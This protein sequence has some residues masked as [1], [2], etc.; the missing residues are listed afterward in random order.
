[1]QEIVEIKDKN[2]PSTQFNHLSTLGEGINC[3][4]W[5]T[6]TPTPAPFVAEARSSSEFYSNK[7]LV[8]FKKS[9]E[10]QTNWVSHWNNFMKELQNYVKKHHTTGL[11]WNPRG[12]DAGASKPVAAPPKAGGPPPPPPPSALA[13]APTTPAKGA[14]VDT[15]ALFASINKGEGITSGLKKVTA[16]MKT[17]NRKDNT[18]LVP[19]ETSKKSEAAPKAAGAAKKGTP[20]IELQGNKWIVEFQDN[21]KSIE[22]K[23]T[24]PKQAIYIYKSDNCVVKI[25]GKINSVCIDGCKKTA[26]VFENAISGCEL[27]NCNSVEVQILGAIPS[28]AID[29]CS[30]VQ[31]FL[32]KEALNANIV[33]SKS[34]AMNILI[35]G[36]TKDADLIELP[37]PEQFQTAIKNNKLITTSMV[38]E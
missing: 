18:S 34:D 17:K 32:S 37:I 35:P 13:A 11:S 26:V 14:A 29:K 6:I 2:R 5:I 3:L 33:S 30:G 20:K 31:L 23:E 1:M 36:A 24:E 10:N 4:G 12:C 16:D 8:Q 25:S 21:N 9:D 19:A 28:I 15:S 22:I 38:H 7:I 27:V